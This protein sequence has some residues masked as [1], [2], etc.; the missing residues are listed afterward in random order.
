MKKLLNATNLPWFVLAA[1]VIGI[2]L[3]FWLLSTGIDKTGLLVSGHPADILLWLLT[4]ATAVFVIV[5]SLPLVEAAKYTFNFPASPMGAVG[6]G[7][8]ALGILAA[9]ILSLLDSA[10]P[11]AAVTAIV[12]FLSAIVLAFCAFCR[13]KGIQPPFLLRSFLCI[14]WVLRLVCLYQ[15]WSP[16]PQL[17]SYVFQLFAN[18]FMMLSFYQRT[19]FDAD[20]G[21]RRAHAIYHLA[22]AFFSC[23]SLIGSWDWFLYGACALWAITDLCRLIPM[24]GWKFTLPK[25]DDSHDP[26]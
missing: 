23:L 4:A 26:A 7:L 12:G 13:W 3:R 9:S 1:G 5:K 8:L 22:A 19:A 20:F 2:G 24:P 18:V 14:Y 16:E 15:L 17:Q 25:K 11:L 10:A 21:N 6:E